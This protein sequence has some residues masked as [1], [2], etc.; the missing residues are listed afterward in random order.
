MA[1]SLNTQFGD[2]EVADK[3][4]PGSAKPRVKQNVVQTVTLQM[5][6]IMY[7]TMQTLWK[8]V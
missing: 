6:Q 8:E 4:N 2:P 3:I 7:L 5:E 1:Q